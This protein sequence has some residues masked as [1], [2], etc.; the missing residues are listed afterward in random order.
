MMSFIDDLIKFGK[1]NGYKYTDLARE[2]YK[3]WRKGCI[4]AE[5]RCR[6]LQKELNELKQKEL[7]KEDK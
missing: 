1:E 7:D 4:E 6:Q 5:E 2:E 3:I